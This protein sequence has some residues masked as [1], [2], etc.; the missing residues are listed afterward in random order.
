MCANARVCRLATVWVLVIA[1]RTHRR[2]KYRAQD[3]QRMPSRQRFL[4]SGQIEYR[5][6]QHDPSD[7]RYTALM[8]E[9]DNGILPITELHG[10]SK[11]HG[12]LRQHRQLMEELPAKAPKSF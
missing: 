9:V 1:I 7:E 4:H 8:S 10:Q 5:H 6:E 11:P 12:K 2:K 3:S